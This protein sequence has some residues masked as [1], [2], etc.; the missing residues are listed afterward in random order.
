MSGIKYLSLISNKQDFTDTNLSAKMTGASLVKGFTSYLE[1]VILLDEIAI[2]IRLCLHKL[3][4]ESVCYFKSKELHFLP[5]L[6][7]YTCDNFSNN[8]IN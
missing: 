8:L 3:P 1:P 2:C 7:D 6:L 4:V 5:E